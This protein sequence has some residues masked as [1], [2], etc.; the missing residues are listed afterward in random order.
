MTD[1]ERLANKLEQ[2]SV[3]YTAEQAQLIREAAEA[4]K[5]AAKAR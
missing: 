3:C 2:L 4:L 5:R 1:L